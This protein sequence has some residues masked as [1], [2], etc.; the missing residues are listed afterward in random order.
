MDPRVESLGKSPDNPDD[1]SIS[2]PLGS[3]EDS[4]SLE[5]LIASF[6]SRNATKS[7]CRRWI[8]NLAATRE[9]DDK[10]DESAIHCLGRDLWDI[11][12]A[13][14]AMA[15][16]SDQQQMTQGMKSLLAKDM[17]IVGFLFLP[18]LL[19]PLD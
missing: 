8:T 3:P 7:I 6:P 18:V 9:L 5:P 17:E 11:R 2:L 19:A 4:T 13:S 12:F 10:V 1:H 16:L 15:L 14:D